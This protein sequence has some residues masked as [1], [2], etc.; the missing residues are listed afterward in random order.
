MF[1]SKSIE[2]GDLVQKDLVINLNYSSLEAYR[3]R[4][5]ENEY[6]SPILVSLFGTFNSIVRNINLSL[7]VSEISR[8]VSFYDNK[9]A[10][11][12]A[13]LE[14]KEV[15]DE[16]YF[17]AL[18]KVEEKLQKIIHLELKKLEPEMVRLK[19]SKF[20]NEII[21]LIKDTDSDKSSI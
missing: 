8:M 5:I 21:E 9:E 20:N 10:F 17:E 2:I 14:Y 16:D 6:H 7:K 1:V 11:S 15:L 18:E 4:L 12:V 13:L 19:D 3:S